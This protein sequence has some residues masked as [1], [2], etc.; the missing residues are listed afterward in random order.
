MTLDHALD[1]DEVAPRGALDM[2]EATFRWMLNDDAIATE[3]LAEGIRNFAADHGKL[4]AF[5][6]GRAEAA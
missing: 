6:A 5:V 1:P 2:D 3:K 4:V